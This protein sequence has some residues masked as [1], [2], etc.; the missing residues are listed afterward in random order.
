MGYEFKV[1]VTAELIN[2]EEFRKTIRDIISEEFKKV[3][4]E[5]ISV[6]DNLELETIDV[7]NYTELLKDIAS[8]IRRNC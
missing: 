7:S 1:G 8:A 4:S 5:E 3:L 6:V 2:G